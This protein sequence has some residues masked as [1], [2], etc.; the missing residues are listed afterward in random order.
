MFEII[1]HWVIL[2]GYVKV[3]KTVKSQEDEPAHSTQYLL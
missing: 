2:N 3:R 1:D